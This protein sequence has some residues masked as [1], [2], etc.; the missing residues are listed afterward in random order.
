MNTKQTSWKGSEEWHTWS[1]SSIALK[2]LSLFLFFIAVMPQKLS[3]HVVGNGS[4]VEIAPF[5]RMGNSLAAVNQELSQ[6][7]SAKLRFKPQSQFSWFLLLLQKSCPFQKSLLSYM[8]PWPS[9]GTQCRLSGREMKWK[10]L[11]KSF[12]KL[13]YYLTQCSRVDL[14]QPFR[15]EGELSRCFFFFFFWQRCT[16]WTES[17]SFCMCMWAGVQ[18][19]HMLKCICPVCQPCTSLIT[20]K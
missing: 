15:S 17:N 18:F 6:G 1:S 19:I 8:G 20:C 7:S 16:F 14:S 5:A 10:L 2:S 12:Q 13:T 3:S 9:Q 4:S 11:C